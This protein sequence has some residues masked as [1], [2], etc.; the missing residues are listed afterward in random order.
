VGKLDLDEAEGVRRAL[1]ALVENGVV[2]RYAEGIEPVYVIGPDQQLVAA[3]YRNTVIHF[4][5]NACI[6][7]LALLRAAEG[8]VADRLAAFWEET[9]RLRDLLKF[10][11]FFA[12]KEIFRG[13][14]V[15]ELRFH[16]SDW[17]RRVQAGSDAVRSMVRGFRPFSSHRVLR[18]FVDAYQIVGDLLEQEDGD[19]PIDE[20]KFLERCMRA[21]RQYHLQRRIHSAASVSQVL[22]RNALRLAE[23]RGILESGPPDL[24]ARRRAFA[25]EVRSVVDRIEAIDALAASRRAGV[26]P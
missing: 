26:I 14:L 21:G 12:E 4:F 15:Q 19:E 23:N 11:F 13:E 2:T 3:Y 20:G 24:A 1:D 5:V 9:L 6:V 18:P 22:F 16:D 10:E 25:D 8:D 17:E 7:E